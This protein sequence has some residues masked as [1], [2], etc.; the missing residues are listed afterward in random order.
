MAVK[1]TVFTQY[2]LFYLTLYTVTTES[3]YLRNSGDTEKRKYNAD[4]SRHKTKI[5]RTNPWPFLPSA[6]SHYAKTKG[7][8]S[9][10]YM[11]LSPPGNQ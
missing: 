5:D 3:A 1:S 2:V 7:H 4:S 6:G 9:Y 11:I 10:P 8:P